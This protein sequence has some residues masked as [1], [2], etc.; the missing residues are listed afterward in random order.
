MFGKK[1]ITVCSITKISITV[2]TCVISGK[3]IEVTNQVEKACTPQAYSAFF[4][5]IR[6]KLHVKQVRL[7][8]PESDTYLKLLTFPKGTVVT[9]ALV[10]EKIKEIIPET[11]VDG[12]MDWKQVQMDKDEIGVQVY[13][14]KKEILAPILTAC[15]EAGIEVVACE[16]PSFAM[17]RMAI[18]VH[19]AFILV[20]PSVKPEFVCAIQDG[21]VL[22]VM[23]VDPLGSL[24]E[25]KHTFIDYIAKTWGIAVHAIA[26]NVPDPVIGL[27]TKTELTG[28][29]MD[30]LNIPVEHGEKPGKRLPFPVIIGI[31]VVLV[32][33][34][35]FLS[36]KLWNGARGNKGTIASVVPQ[37]TSAPT[38][39]E[40]PI[41]REN[42]KIEVQNGS[43]V[44]GLAGKGKK[45]L[46]TAGYTAVT[47]ANADNYDYTGVTVKGKTPGTAAFVVLDIKTA[48]P[49]ASASSA[50]LDSASTV[51]AI[52]ILGKD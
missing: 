3:S 22:E 51:E 39:T 21:K 30:V 13:V 8:L 5:E 11:I 38:P 49:S 40:T 28:D 6:S 16:P 25:T 42:I 17:A 36:L 27:A 2:S 29:D 10:G 37:A 41:V 31:I 1:T 48:Y 4:S 19:E 50:L 26:T 15:D 18:K 12:F 46:E 9:R 7:L 47:T 24:E 20:Y 23:S 52:V 43:G 32:V 44:V 33:G 35:G 34:I 14:V 45:V